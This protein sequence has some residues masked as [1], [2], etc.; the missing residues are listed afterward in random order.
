MKEKSFSGI[1][2]FVY[3]LVIISI[4]LAR[5]NSVGC[6]TYFL[7]AIETSPSI[8][9]SPIILQNITNSVIYTGNTSAKVTISN[10][11]DIDVLEVLNQ[12]TNGWKLQLI[13]FNGVNITRLNNCTIWFLDENTTSVQIKIIEGV[14]KQTSGN[15][16]NFTTNTNITITATTNSKGTSLIYTYLKILKPGTSTYLLCTITFEILDQ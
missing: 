1:I 5:L 4:L 8:S 2:R 9:P 14:Y 6:S 13:A 16:Y 12:A 7:M 15:W 3:L 10:T 11:D